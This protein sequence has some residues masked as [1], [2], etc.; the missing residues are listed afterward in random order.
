M[1]FTLFGTGTKDHKYNSPTI[2][3]PN[4]ATKEHTNAIQY[5]RK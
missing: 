5:L 3:N 1:G 2:I 4:N